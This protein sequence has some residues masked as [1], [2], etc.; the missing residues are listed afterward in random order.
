M[1]RIY[2]NMYAR[3]KGIQ[4]SR[5]HLYKGLYLLDRQTFYEWI[6]EQNSFH[7]IFDKYSASGF[8]RMEAPSVDRIDSTIGYRRS[9]MRIITARENCRLGSISKHKQRKENGANSSRYENVSWDK[10]RN[11]WTSYV[12]HGGKQLFCGRFDNEEDA[13]KAVNEKRKAIQQR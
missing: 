3:T 11:K 10:S 8:K 12:L 13:A 4:K 6:D 5:V 2:N 7:E 1:Q 9:N